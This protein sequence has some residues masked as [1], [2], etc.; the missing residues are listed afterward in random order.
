[1][2]SE[3]SDAA[4]ATTLLSIPPLSRMLS[5]WSPSRAP[6]TPSITSA[7]RVSAFPRGDSAGGLPL[8]RPMGED[9]FPW[10]NTLPGGNGEKASP[11][12][13]CDFISDEKA[14]RLT[15]P[16]AT[17]IGDA[18]EVVAYQL[19]LWNFSLVTDKIDLSVDS[20]WVVDLPFSSYT[21]GSYE[22]VEFTVQV[23]IPA[24]VKLG[25]VDVALLTATSQSDPLATD[26]S[27][28]STYVGIGRTYLPMLCK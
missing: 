2:S 17:L 14:P 8:L 1:M 13:S 7:L 6:L 24:G 25:D 3:T 9:P 16:E 11:A 27:S 4:D 28:L 19:T 20:D 5:R 21:L 18:G 23:T 10:T 26:A 12:R 15:P 22:F